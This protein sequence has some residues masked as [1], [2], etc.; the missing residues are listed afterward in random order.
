MMACVASRAKSKMIKLAAYPLCSMAN[1]LHFTVNRRTNK[2]SELEPLVT[3]REAKLRGNEG[4]K[5]DRDNYNN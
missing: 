4:R 5:K 3:I 1:G 2:G